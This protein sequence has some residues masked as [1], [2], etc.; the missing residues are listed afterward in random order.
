MPR[1][2]TINV[3]LIPESMSVNSLAYLKTTGRFLRLKRAAS[4]GERQIRGIFEDDA[5]RRSQDYTLTDTVD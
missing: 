5:R 2:L 3:E 1:L 4:N